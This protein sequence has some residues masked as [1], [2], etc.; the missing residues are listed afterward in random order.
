LAPEWVFIFGMAER[1]SM[2]KTRGIARSGAG[3]PMN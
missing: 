3:G 2:A 1:P